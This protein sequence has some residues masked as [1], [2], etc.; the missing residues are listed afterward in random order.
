MHGRINYKDYCEIIPT[1]KN[2]W[3]KNELFLWGF[4]ITL[5]GKTYSAW[6]KP[7]IYLQ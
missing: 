5:R 4:F 1:G 2:I 7:G 3:G 6:N